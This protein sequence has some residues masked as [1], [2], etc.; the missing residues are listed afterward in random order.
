M[1]SCR[2]LDGVS[3]A[4]PDIHRKGGRASRER[5]VASSCHG[6]GQVP[7][8]LACDN[9]HGQLLHVCEV[10]ARPAGDRASRMWHR[11]GKPKGTTD[12]TAPQEHQAATPRVPHGTV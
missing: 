6:L 10:A 4:L 12:D 3:V 1:G 2:E 11:E 9:I 7:E 5:F 8:W